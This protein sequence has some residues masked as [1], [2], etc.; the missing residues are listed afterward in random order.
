MQYDFGKTIKNGDF[1]H[2]GSL[3]KPPTVLRTAVTKLRARHR[4]QPNTI[5][6]V[7]E[8]VFQTWPLMKEEFTAPNSDKDLLYKASYDHNGGSD[9]TNCDIEKLETR[10]T[11]KE[12]DPVIHYGIIAS[13]NQVMRH[14]G[15]R[16]KIGREKGIL[17]FEMEAAGLMDDFP[18][19]VIRGICD[20]SDTHK[21]KSWQPYAAVTAA[22]YA[23]ELLS[24]IPPAE[25]ERSSA[26]VDMMNAGQ[27]LFFF[28]DPKKL[29]S[30]ERC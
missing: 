5:Q 1:I 30:N 6:S 25:I 21:N 20:Y 14:G 22:A 23:K 29:S 4:R 28:T 26:A 8:K 13:A 9:C 10:V 15:T 24:I 3:N 16:D 11:R 17:C 19:I 27:P 7:L 12:S 2:T 18:C